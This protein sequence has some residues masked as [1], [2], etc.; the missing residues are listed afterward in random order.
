MGYLFSVLCI[1]EMFSLLQGFYDEATYV[2]E[3]RVVLL[4]VGGAGKSALLECMKKLC[5]D[6]GKSDTSE[7]PAL[8]AQRLSSLAPTVGL[9]V[10]KLETGNERLLVWDL[11]GAAQ[12][13]SIWRRY[14]EDAEALVFVVDATAAEDVMADA[15][16]SLRGLLKS[17]S[18]V[19]APLLV[20]ANKQDLENAIDP[21]KTSLALDL[22]SDA[23]MRPQC[24]QPCSAATGSGIREGLEWL[25]HRLRYPAET[26][27]TSIKGT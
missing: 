24:V 25:V 7:P 21:V 16:D 19:H 18:L 3:R 9:N 13:R 26:I 1:I 14:V 12:L 11:G 8:P 23:E 15:R 4:G 2:P 20:F 10:A 5:T 17:E 27:K 6:W 22:L